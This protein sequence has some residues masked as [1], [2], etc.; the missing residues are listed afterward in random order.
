M[1]TVEGGSEDGPKLYYE[2]LST[3]SKNK[4]KKVLQLENTF[5]YIS[6]RVR[7]KSDL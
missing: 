1:A 6:T 7:E 2:H 3:K 5:C 4:Y